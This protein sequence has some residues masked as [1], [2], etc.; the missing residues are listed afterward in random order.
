MPEG[1]TIH[2]AARL[3]FALLGGCAVAADS[4]QGRFDEGAALLDGARLDAIEAYGK[5]LL[6]AFSGDRL[7][8]VHLGLFGRFRLGA[9]PAPEPRGAIRLR[10]RAATGWL[11]LSGPTACEIFEAADRK[12]LLARI[13][14]DPLRADAR[15]G[16]AIERILG[17]V[18][19]LGALLMDQ[20]VI[21][22]IGNVYR[23]ELAFRARIAPGTPGRELTR[24]AVM[25]I[26][27]D[28]RALMRA[29]ERSGRI[30]TTDPADRP[31]P[32]GAVRAG[33]Q[34]YVY[35]RTG[36]P[37]RL[38]T[39]PI[40]RGELAGRTVFWCPQCQPAAMPS[41]LS[42]AAIRERKLKKPRVAAGQ[43]SAS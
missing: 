27:R 5:H 32:S 29:G 37:C 39:T 17:S 43:A 26:W 23:A 1:H 14:P 21:G 30:V 19:P 15:P 10:L 36:R 2:R 13:G 4:P 41:S 18:T 16:P 40:A 6:Y 22:G 7:L 38:C 34:Y 31:H 20:T 35:G 8:H 33:E 24:D 3:Q 11:T 42:S 28:A 12:R 9:G 25:A